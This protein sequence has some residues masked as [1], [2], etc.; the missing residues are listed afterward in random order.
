M[1]WSVI[2]STATYALAGL[3]AYVV[4]RR[5][6]WSF[7]LLVVLPLVGALTGF[8]GGSVIGNRRMSLLSWNK[9]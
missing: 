5:Q 7:L 3:W 4:F 6:T 2:F 8:V 1:L 9:T